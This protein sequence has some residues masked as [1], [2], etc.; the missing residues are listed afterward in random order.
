[1]SWEVI[2]RII[3]K[4]ILSLIEYNIQDAAGVIQLCVGQQAGCVL[5]VYAMKDIFAS[6][7]TEGIYWL[8]HSNNLNCNATLLNIESICLYLSKILIN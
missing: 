6:P 3:A 1:M 4:A 7:N 2:R 8:M 5:A